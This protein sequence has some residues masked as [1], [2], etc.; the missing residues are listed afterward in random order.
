MHDI[1][2]WYSRKIKCTSYCLISGSNNNNNDMSYINMSTIYGKSWDKK[3]KPNNNFQ[4]DS[5]DAFGEKLNSLANDDVFRKQF[6]KL[7]QRDIYEQECNNSMQLDSK[8]DS[9][10]LQ[11]GSSNNIHSVKHQDIVEIPLNHEQYS[12]NEGTLFTTPYSVTL[13]PD[14]GSSFNCT[15]QMF[16]KH[17]TYI[18][19]HYISNSSNICKYLNYLLNKHIFHNNDSLFDEYKLLASNHISICEEE[20][21]KKN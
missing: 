5:D 4:Y 3:Y 9:D 8:I 12:E 16:Y 10:L 1:V 21:K 2:T 18:K 13:G 7:I 11:N 6:N 19:M 15:Y 14:I 20:I 17:L